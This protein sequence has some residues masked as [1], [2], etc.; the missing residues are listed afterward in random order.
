MQGLKVDAYSLVDG[1]TDLLNQTIK[2]DCFVSGTTGGHILFIYGL[3]QMKTTN[4]D[5]Q[6]FLL[7]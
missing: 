3:Y 5:V 7:L 1:E 4:G 6:M 2:L